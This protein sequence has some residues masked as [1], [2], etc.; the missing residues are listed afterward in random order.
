VTITVSTGTPMV[1]VPDMYC[2][3]RKQ[4]ADVAASA[5]LKLKFDG[6]YGRVVDQDPAAKSQVHKGST[7]TA[8]TGPG[9]RC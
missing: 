5:G 9:T 2:M 1:A 6:D 8:F 4:A 3:T 7:V